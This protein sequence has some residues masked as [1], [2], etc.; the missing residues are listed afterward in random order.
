MTGYIE[1]VI[2]STALDSNKLVRVYGVAV[3]TCKGS[4]PPREA[5]SLVPPSFLTSYSTTQGGVSNGGL[6]YWTHL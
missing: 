2:V 5:K 1:K 3:T 6:D 4:T